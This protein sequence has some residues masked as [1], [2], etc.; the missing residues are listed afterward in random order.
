MFASVGSAPATLPIAFP[1]GQTRPLA[2]I[3]REDEQWT[4][5]D[6]C[7]LWTQHATQRPPDVKSVTGG[8]GSQT[9]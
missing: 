2:R 7:H 9:S 5:A 6:L 8:A 4:W 3:V 1:P